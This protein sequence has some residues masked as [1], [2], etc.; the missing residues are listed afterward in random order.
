MHLFYC[1]KVHENE[2]DLGKGGNAESLESGNDG[3]G[4]AWGII[5]IDEDPK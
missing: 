3:T 1:L 4:L 2:D 5:G